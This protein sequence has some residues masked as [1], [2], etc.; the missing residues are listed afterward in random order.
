MVFLL[1]VTLH[2]LSIPKEN[3]AVHYDSVDWI[4]HL[5]Q[6]NGIHCLMAKTDIQDAFRIIPINPSDYHLLGFHG[7]TSFI[8]TNVYLWAPAVRVKFL[9]NLVL[10]YNG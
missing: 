8:M 7:M 9:N 4:I 2:L 6:Q 3:S 10:H 1:V 5:V